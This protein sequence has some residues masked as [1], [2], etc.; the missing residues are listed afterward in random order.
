M[1]IDKWLFNVRAFK[2]RSIAADACNGGKVK[3]NGR[4]IKPSHII[5][6]G[7]SVH[8]QTPAGQKIFK[9]ITLI[10]RRVSAEKAKGC[11]DDLSPVPEG[12]EKMPSVFYKFPNRERGSG[13]PT[14]K[15]RRDMDRLRRK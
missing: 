9:A 7:D 13:R 15:E 1:R 8:F 2:S 5:A 14:K 11:Y 4:S 10:E 3:L 12:N 6:A